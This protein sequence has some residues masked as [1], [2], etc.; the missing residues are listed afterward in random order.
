[1]FGNAACIWKDSELVAAKWHIGE[2]IGGQVAVSDHV[3]ESIPAGSDQLACPCSLFHCCGRADP[4]PATPRCRRTAARLQ[5]FI[6]GVSDAL[7]LRARPARSGCLTARR[8]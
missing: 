8:A 1:M 3:A 4:G 5:T 2:H 6:T 7:D